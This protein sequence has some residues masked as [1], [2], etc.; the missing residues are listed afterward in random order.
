M[1]LSTNRKIKIVGA[2]SL[3]PL[4]ASQCP[5]E[6]KPGCEIYLYAHSG[7]GG[8][9]HRATGNFGDLRGTAVHQQVSSFRVLKGRWELFLNEGYDH[10][11]GQ[12]VKGNEQNPVSPDNE[13]DSGRCLEPS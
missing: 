10:P 7:F 3:L 2:L 9:N 11:Y 13:I 12:F 1:K 5:P 8:G 4:M 6:E